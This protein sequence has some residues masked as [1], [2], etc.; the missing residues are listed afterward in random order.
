MN[1]LLID[2]WGINNTSEYLNGLIY[3][4]SKDVNLTVVTNYFFICRTE[5]SFDLRKVFFKHSEKMKN[6]I[7]RKIIRGF[8]YYWAYKRIL[9]ILK[10]KQFDVIHVNWFLNYKQ[11][12]MF[13]KRIKNK[14]KLKIIY[15]AHNVLPHD[16]GEKSIAAVGKIYKLV[17]V[18][19]LHGEAIKQEFCSYFPDY[20]YKTFVQKH[21]ANISPN[22]QFDEKRINPIIT[23]FFEK[24]LRV[25]ISFGALFYNKGVDRIAKYW[26]NHKPDALLIIA[27]R[28]VY[29]Y[30]EFESLKEE[31]RT[32]QN[33]LFVDGFVDD[34]TLNYL[35]T[36]SDIIVLPYR[37]A[38]MS[39]VV[40][41]AAD[42]KKTI[43]FTDCGAIKEYLQPGIDSIACEND[44]IA[45]YK[46][47]SFVLSLSK[48]EMAKMGESLCQHIEESCNWEMIGKVLVTQVYIASRN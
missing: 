1:V 44:D 14:T 18:I 41:T 30:R 48:E 36:R 45:F 27:G 13:V 40:F 12:A 46:K 3:G 24:N 17:D 22:T 4:V 21:G 15:T 20:A 38:S 16:R 7:S 37:H 29:N 23:S 11:D 25:F 43:L 19:I 2:P 5:S 34:N 35:I 8:E 31:L 47:L 9:R 39:G 10:E 32:T 33:V 28:Q 42:F 6:G 26:I